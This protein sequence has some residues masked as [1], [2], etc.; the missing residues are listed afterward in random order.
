MMVDNQALL[1]FFRAFFSVL[2][3]FPQD[4]YETVLA[5]THF[6]FG[7]PQLLWVYKTITDVKVPPLLDTMCLHFSVGKHIF[8]HP[9]ITIWSTK[10]EGRC[11]IKSPFSFWAKCK[12]VY[13]KTSQN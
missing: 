5:V 2:W 9:K 6:E 4:L 12:L 8:S 13:H 1:P 7:S 3:L 11:R 10:M